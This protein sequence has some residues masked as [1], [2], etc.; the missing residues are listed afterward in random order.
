DMNEDGDYQGS[1][2]ESKIYLQTHPLS[3]RVLKE[4]SY[5]YHQLYK[6]DSAQYFM[7]LVDKVMGAMIY[8]G[9][10]KTPETAIFSLGVID[11]EHFI[12]N[13][14]MTPAHK[15]VTPS[16]SKVLMY[17]VDALSDEGTH[18]N[19]YF[20]LQHARDKMD[21]DEIG[22]EPIVKKKPKKEPKKDTK[23]EN[24]KDSKKDKKD[25]A[26]EPEKPVTD[27]IPPATPPST[28]APA[29]N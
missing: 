18:T 15:S 12:N 24:K 17:I 25:I 14:G 22:E 26:P 7:D 5:S 4:R 16:K 11:G 28:T 3:L 6:K 13:V 10:G 29:G 27:S 21:E 20:I 23:K 2:D 1:L 19:Y 9:K 8:S